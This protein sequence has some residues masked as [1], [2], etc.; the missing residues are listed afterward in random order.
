MVNK[1][2]DPTAEEAIKEVA[3]ILAKGYL[4]LLAKRREDSTGTAPVEAAPAP[5][6]K[7]RQPRKQAQPAEIVLPSPPRRSEPGA[8]IPE[9]TRAAIAER[10]NRLSTLTTKE[11]KAEYER[12]LGR[13]P[14]TVHKQFM[15]RRI[16]WEIQAQAEG[17]LPDTIREYACRI[18]EQTDLFKR[19]AENL[20]KRNATTT[21]PESNQTER[22]RRQR[23]ARRI[24][25]ARDPRLPA[26]GSLLILKRGRETVRVTVLETGFEYAG[27]RYRSL[28]AVARAVA[29]RSV[30]A[31]EFFGLADQEAVTPRG[32]TPS[33]PK[34]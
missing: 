11:L 14:Q 13:P 24:P 5:K 26:P 1:K 18:A 17:R 20:K 32:P 16:A 9:A 2:Y 15:F 8:P 3:E 19:V 25:K 34:G 7:P 33:Q 21:P 23:P 31:F 22:R 4:N 28:T 30:N 12:L 27:Q 6:P 29:G 10:L